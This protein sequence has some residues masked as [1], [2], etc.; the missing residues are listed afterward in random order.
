MLVVIPRHAL[1]NHLKWIS[2]LLS[3]FILTGLVTASSK[4]DKSDEELN[5]EMKK[6]SNEM[7]EFK[8][9]EQF[10]DSKDEIHNHGLLET[11]KELSVDLDDRHP[12]DTEELHGNDHSNDGNNNDGE[13]RINLREEQLRNRITVYQQQLTTERTPCSRDVVQ[14]IKQFF[15]LVIISLFVVRIVSALSRFTLDPFSK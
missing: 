3:C 5:S 11:S 15:I 12:F 14:I 13:I 9:T 10:L 6:L 8:N 4:E 7:E 1:M 2:F